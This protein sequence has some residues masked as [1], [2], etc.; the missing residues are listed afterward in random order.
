MESL[1]M[2]SQSCI[3]PKNPL[4]ELTVAYC[5]SMHGK[6]NYLEQMKII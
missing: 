1:S 2:E 6:E 5:E 4:K 3:L